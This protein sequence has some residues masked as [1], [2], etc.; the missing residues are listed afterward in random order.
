LARPVPDPILILLLTTLAVG[1]P[2][3]L[4]HGDSWD[5]MRRR[6]LTEAE[7][8]S[9]S[10]SVEVLVFPSGRTLWSHRAHEPMIPA[11][12]LKIATS[13]A[14]LK[15]LGPNHRFRTAL[16]TASPVE[17]GIVSGDIWLRSEGDIFWTVA[18]AADLAYRLRARGIETVRGRLLVDNG[19]FSPPWE[20]VCLDE[21]CEDSYNPM[22]S[23]S[24]IEFNSVLVRVRPSSSVGKP[25]VVEWVPR[26]RFLQVVNEARTAPKKAGTDLVMSLLE[27]DP[28]GRMRLH[29][30]G[31]LPVS[32]A[33]VVERRH[34]VTSPSVFVA[35]VVTSVLESTGIRVESG[36]TVSPSSAA[37]PKEA[38]LL[39]EVLSPPLAETIHGLNRHS[40]NFMA[41]ML[42][43]SM[44]AAVMG[45]P[46][47]EAKGIA[48][49][50]QVLQAL[51][52]STADCL[53][54]T[55]SGLS[56]QCRMTARALGRILVSAY[57][58]A[59]LGPAFMASLA[60]NGEEGTMRRRLTRSPVTLRG[61]T[62]T[63]N[64][65]V[66]FAG[67]VSAPN[68]PTYGVVLILNGVHDPP[69]AKRAV[70]V[71]LEKLGMFGPPTA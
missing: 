11:S 34:S 37:L 62:G 9:E 64:D 61:K 29:I 54:K 42:L 51:G 65:V 36:S 8:S 68:R 5:E 20:R 44:G 46:G 24:A 3:V 19:Y 43:R 26:G 10:V 23:G 58:E 59:T 17:D 53:L 38:R 30:S 25:P 28:L 69:R 63:L 40:N 33:A 18:G 21:R 49:V 6:L 56:R 12:L 13:Y 39:A 27:P 7:R 4:A 32:P 57:G 50:N 45:P 15:T 35:E 2:A 41:E 14:A 67:Y 52:A 16:Y 71:F 31:R 22:V 60:V 47:T 55:G 66:G 48:T 1:V 70:D